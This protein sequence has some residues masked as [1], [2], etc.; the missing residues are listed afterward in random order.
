MHS[1]HRTRAT[2]S[3]LK[4]LVWAPAGARRV[5]VSP[6]PTIS[7]PAPPLRVPPLAAP[8]EFAVI[9]AGGSCDSIFMLLVIVHVLFVK[10][11]RAI[12]VVVYSIIEVHSIIEVQSIVWQSNRSSSICAT[13]VEVH[14]IPQQSTS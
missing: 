10:R 6:Q 13:V 12:I 14:S 4:L 5:S 2:H 7:A 9:V 8:S 1:R 11:Q 3:A